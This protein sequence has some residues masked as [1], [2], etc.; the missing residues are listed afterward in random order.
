[1]RALFR[2]SRAL[3]IAPTSTSDDRTNLGHCDIL[4]QCWSW[5]LLHARLCVFGVPTSS[6]ERGAKMRI[7]PFSEAVFDCGTAPLD[8]AAY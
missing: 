3:T 8:D 1:M 7:P 6:D 4:A 5:A 2:H